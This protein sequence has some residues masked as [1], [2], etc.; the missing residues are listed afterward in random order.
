[1]RNF[2]FDDFEIIF[3]W[4]NFKYKNVIYIFGRVIFFINNIYFYN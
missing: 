2:S 3:I 4:L 1:M